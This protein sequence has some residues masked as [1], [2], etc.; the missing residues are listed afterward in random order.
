MPRYFIGMFQPAGVVPGPE[1]LVPVMREMG[2]L[3][4]DLGRQGSLVF[5]NG[6]D[7]RVS[8]TVLTSDGTSFDERQGSFLPGDIQLGGLTI[9]DVA[10]EAAARTIATRMAEITHLPI[11]IRRFAERS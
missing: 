10:D 3:M 4:D 7:P 1:V 8:P 11:E 9:V 6:F 2:A 5:S